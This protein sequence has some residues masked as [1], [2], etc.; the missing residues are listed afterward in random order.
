MLKGK[1]VIIFDLGGVLIDLHVE[2]SFAALVQLGVDASILTERNCLINSCMMQFDRGDISKE[3]M[4]AYMASQIPQQTRDAFGDRLGSTLHSVWNMM[5]GDYAACKFNRIKELRGQGY[6]VV[7]LSNTN[8]GHW[9]EIERKFEAAMGEPLQNYFDAFYLSYRMRRR[10]PEH[11]IFTELLEQEGV[12]PGE[13]IF[14]DDSV[15][16]CEAARCVG[17]EAVQLER[18][19]AWGGELM[20]D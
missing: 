15:E 2:R 7:M 12:L 10:K 19:A 8:E 20:T 6:R 13:C 3:E 11:D 14:F 4:Y 1:K 5:L 9:D 17:I 18:N 16:N